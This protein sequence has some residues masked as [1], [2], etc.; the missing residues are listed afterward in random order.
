MLLNVENL[1]WVVILKGNGQSF[2]I[3]ILRKLFQDLLRKFLPF[4]IKFCINF[5]MR[6]L[7]PLYTLTDILSCDG[8]GI[9]RTVL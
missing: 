1:K 8:Q 9:G 6:F 5:L 4:P 3:D 2:C 7:L